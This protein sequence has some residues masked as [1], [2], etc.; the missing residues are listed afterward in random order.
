MSYDEAGGIRGGGSG[1]GVRFSESERGDDVLDVVA[2]R[3]AHSMRADAVGQLPERLQLFLSLYYQE[4]L[5]YREIA[6]V[7]S[8][9]VG[10]ALQL[11]TEATKRLRGSAWRQAAAGQRFVFGLETLR[12]IRIQKR[13]EGG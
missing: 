6:E 7:L 10:R 11:H 13:R 9:T 8:V 4:A 3:E 2:Q 12:R 1:S 5:T